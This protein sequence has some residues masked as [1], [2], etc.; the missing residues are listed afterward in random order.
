MLQVYEIQTLLKLIFDEC[1]FLSENATRECHANGTWAARSDYSECRPLDQKDE[2]FEN[3]WDIK[4]A[5]TIYS[6]GYGLSLIALVIALWI[7]LYFR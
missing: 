2:S 4:D 3:L 5:H 7:F 1:I 6:I